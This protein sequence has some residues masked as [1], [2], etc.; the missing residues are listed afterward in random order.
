MNQRFADAVVEEQLRQGKTVEDAR[1]GGCSGC[2]EVGAFGKEAYI[3]T[4]YLNL[5]KLLELAMHDGAD[6]R[7][8]Q[9]LGPPTGH[10][11]ADLDEFLEKPEAIEL[12][13]GED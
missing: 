7:T 3:L 6:P 10:E 5:P 12:E 13:G 11:F 1:A 8:G 2:V 9:R 4:G